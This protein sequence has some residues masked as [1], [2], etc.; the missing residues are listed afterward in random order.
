MAQHRFSCARR[1]RQR[2]V[3]E[4]WE[5][6]K[7]VEEIYQ[8]CD[9]SRLRAHRLARGWTL[10]DAVQEYRILTQD[11][12]DAARLDADQLGRWETTHHR[13]RAHTID[14][15]CRLY[16]TSTH[17]LGLA[18]DY[19]PAALPQPRS[20]V[21]DSLVSSAQD[22][23]PATTSSPSVP[24]DLAQRADH[25]RRRLDRTLAQA[26]IGPTQLDL[27]DER[28]QWLR[29]HYIYEPPAPMLV[30]LLA[31]IEEVRALAADRQPATVQ[32]HLSE[33]TAVLATLAADALMKLGYLRQA[34]AWYGTA[35]AA[36]DD[37]AT[38]ELRARVRAQAAMLPY[39]YGPLDAAISLA[40]EARMIARQRPSATGAFAAAAEARALARNGDTGGAEHAI[41]IA[42]HTFERCEQ[43]PDDDA[44]AFPHCR[45][46]LYL[47]GAYTHL[48][49]TR[50]A[51]HVQQQ[52][53][54]LYPDQAGIDPALLR[55]EE[56]ICLAHDRSL[57]EACQMA[58]DTYVQV[59]D[60]HRT[61]I[62]AA[63][64]RHVLDV[65]PLAMR[66]ARAARQLHDA[67]QLPARG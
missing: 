2:A 59:P 43:G 54:A 22:L 21:E 35:R 31:E 26:S 60:A 16:S 55:L 19:R 49:R 56:A 66:S 36:A 50:Q 47:S 62:L 45:F 8:C 24:G 57:T 34:H 67:L 39:Y 37:S 27:L 14:L 15:L 65:L 13:P 33:I 5:L 1:L 40:R 58:Q 64:A 41:T 48:G 4:G 28:V 42:Q 51:R 63:R 20:P 53:L 10:Q 44:F 52:A 11:V 61:P 30:T 17:Q 46:L 7:T 6:E 23:E 18:G 32:A 25:T 38:V 29:Y 9:V 12:L 3:T